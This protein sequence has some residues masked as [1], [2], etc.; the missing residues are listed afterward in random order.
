MAGLA[1]LLA[2]LLGW[3]MAVPPEAQVKVSGSAAYVA[4]GTAVH[5]PAAD[6]ARLAAR[7][8]FAM[9]PG[10]EMAPPVYDPGLPQPA[11]AQALGFRLG[12]IV[13][14][15]AGPE[16]LLIV[17]GGGLQRLRPGDVLPDGRAIQAITPTGLV[18]EDPAGPVTLRL[19]NQGGLAATVP[20]PPPNEGALDGSAAGTAGTPFPVVPAGDDPPVPRPG[21]PWPAAMGAPP[22]GWPGAET[23]PNRVGGRGPPPSAAAVPPGAPD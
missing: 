16:A 23:I 9:A 11:E 10:L 3:T 17:E 13:S 8:P 20:P 12:G 7:P 19:F 1:L 4:R 2:L 18:L 14:T 15:E 22:A 5:D 6:L 21:E